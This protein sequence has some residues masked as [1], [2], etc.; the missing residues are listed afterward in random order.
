MSIKQVVIF[1]CLVA[2]FLQGCG[3]VSGEK[4]VTEVLQDSI[5]QYVS[6]KADDPASYEPLET[7]LVDTV[8]FLENVEKQLRFSENAV[9]QF[10]SYGKSGDEFREKY[11]MDADTYRSM[12][13]SIL[14]SPDPKSPAAFI[15]AHK[16]RLKNRFGALTMT[17]LVFEFRPDL[18][19]YHAYDQSTG[20]SKGYP[21]G[22]PGR[23]R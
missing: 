6:K 12:R 19:I 4:T 5:R 15:V 16:C 8:T 1:P 2:L 3:S 21:G 23:T 7:A 17:V 9:A 11:V 20:K 18:S 10:S 14:S 13:D 22:L